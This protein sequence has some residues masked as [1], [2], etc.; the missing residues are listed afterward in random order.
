MKP[1]LEIL[2]PDGQALPILASFQN[3]KR[4]SINNAQ[5]AALDFILSI[6]R[7]LYDETLPGWWRKGL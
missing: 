2:L 7:S 1:G 6:I 5:S 4:N 3:K